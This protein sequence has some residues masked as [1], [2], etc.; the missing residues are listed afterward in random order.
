M[1]LSFIWSKYGFMIKKIIFAAALVLLLIGIYLSFSTQNHTIPTTVGDQS[2]EDTAHERLVLKFGIPS[3]NYLEE[4]SEVAP[5]ATL[6]DILFPAGLDYEDIDRLVKISKPTFDFRNIRSGHKIHFF[7]DKDSA[8]VLRYFVYEINKLHYLKVSNLDS[9]AVGLE[10][11]PIRLDTV[12]C[13]GTINSSLWLSMKKAGN[14]PNLALALADI[15]AWTIDFY[16]IQKGDSYK[17]YYVAQYADDTYVGIKNI[18]A[19]K[20]VHRGEANFAFIYKQNN[21]W[22]YFD[23]EGG[24]L[25][26]AFL[27]APL[28]FSRIS[29]RFSNSRLHPVLKIRRPHHGVDYAAPTGTPVHAIGDGY[30][31]LAAWSGGYGRRVLI[32]HNSKYETSYAHLSRFGKGIK[33]GVKVKQGDIIGYV[34]SSGLATG[35]HLDFRFYDSGVA[36]DPLK[37]KSPPAIPISES[38]RSDYDAKM[39]IWKKKLR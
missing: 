9:L 24:S 28:K 23:D 3:Q 33:S 15:Y 2:L 17:V 10:Q 19:S 7:F 1:R 6:S 4:E 27:K 26:R 12:F 29:S 32:K 8:K 31:K 20:F 22:D 11:K 30:V 39:K 13:R 35:P 38:N 14:D 36:V 21:K 16:G 37:V 25:R 18:L 5:G 34:G